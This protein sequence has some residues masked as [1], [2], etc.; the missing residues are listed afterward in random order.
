MARWISPRIQNSP[1]DGTTRAMAGSTAWILKSQCRQTIPLLSDATGSVGLVKFQIIDIRMVQS[2]DDSARQKRFQEQYAA[3]NIITSRRRWGR[4]IER[5]QDR[6]VWRD[7]VASHRVSALDSF[8]KGSSPHSSNGYHHDSAPGMLLRT[9][10]RSTITVASLS[11]FF[12]TR[13]TWRTCTDAGSHWR[14]D[15]R[16]F[17]ATPSQCRAHGQ[18]TRNGVD[19]HL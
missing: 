11:P 18:S 19:Q 3:R 5:Q 9:A 14:C 17:G 4:R 7:W 6:Q 12:A 8:W 13:E 10:I 2:Q 1:I 16:G 15:N